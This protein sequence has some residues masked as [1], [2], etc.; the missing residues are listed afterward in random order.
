MSDAVLTLPFCFRI[1][2]PVLA[3]FQA[4]A[5][6]L[7]HWLTAELTDSCIG[8]Q[9]LWVTFLQRPHVDLQP[10]PLLLPHK[11]SEMIF[12][13]S[14]HA[15]NSFR[16]RKQRQGD[17]VPITWV[18]QEPRFSRKN[19]GFLAQRRSPVFRSSNFS[20]NGDY[21]FFLK[22][23]LEK[24]SLTKMTFFRSTSFKYQS[25]RIQPQKAL[26]V[27]TVAKYLKTSYNRIN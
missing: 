24:R 5:H 26:N 23:I 22:Y 15:I 18:T 3:E 2:F 6:M 16:I 19:E 1:F 12:K 9:L 11:S 14:Q 25:V 8:S 27:H 7:M 4:F 13:S 17:V 21:N 10:V 20:K